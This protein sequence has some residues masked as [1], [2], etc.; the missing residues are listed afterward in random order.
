MPNWR[1]ES[2]GQWTA[3]AFTVEYLQGILAKTLPKTPM[4]TSAQILALLCEQPSLTRVDA[5][6]FL[7]KAHSAV[8]RSVKK[9]REAGGPRPVGP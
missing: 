1:F 5:A 4:K 3:F 7:G 9:A 6:V 8:A 2:S